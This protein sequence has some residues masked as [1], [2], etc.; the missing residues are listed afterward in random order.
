MITRRF[1]IAPA[2]AR[3]ICC[4]RG[5]TGSVEGF[6]EKQ[7]GRMAYLRITGPVSQL[8]LS[9]PRH[10]M[11]PIE[12]PTEIP[13]EHA[14]VLL[15]AC[16]GK[17]SFEQSK[18]ALPDG[19]DAVVRR[20]DSAGALALVS[21]TFPD[22]ESADDFAAPVWFGADV[23][24]DAYTNGDL[25]LGGIPALGDIAIADTALDVLLDVL[26]REPGPTSDQVEDRVAGV[27]TEQADLP[28]EVL[29]G[30]AEGMEQ[31]IADPDAT[32]VPEE[33]LAAGATVSSLTRPANGHRGVQS[34]SGGR[35]GMERLVSGQNAAVG[36]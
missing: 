5:S 7:P 28:H 23:T 1:L 14:S 25:A 17:I 2:L 6:F 21:V 4:R 13:A 19:R 18:V 15:G 16:P 22:R 11:D 36:A 12:A 29:L 26:D 10:D 8:V 3:L 24:D 34:H 32:D 33:P 27:P 31:A 30:L 35:I 9:V 20:F